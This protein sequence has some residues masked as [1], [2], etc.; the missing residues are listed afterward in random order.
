MN[1][2]YFTHFQ[3]I[4]YGFF[5]GFFKFKKTKK[6]QKGNQEKLQEEAYRFNL[7]K[8]EFLF[9]AW[10]LARINAKISV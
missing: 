7:E 6:K 4:I 2:L 10:I 8:N 5:E 9:T 1:F 3:I